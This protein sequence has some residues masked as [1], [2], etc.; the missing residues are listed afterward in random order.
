MN[1]LLLPGNS[2]RHEKWIEDLRK[3]LASHFDITE[4]Q[5]YRHWQSG[6]EKA[7]VDYE[8]SVAQ[9]K[10]DQLKPYTVIAKSI[11]TVIAAKGTAEGKLHP[12]KLILLGIPINGGAPQAPF[13]EWLEKIKLPIVIVQNTNDPLGSF[14]DVRS[15]FEFKNRNILYVELPG[16]THDYLDFRAIENLI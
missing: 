8:L 5:H 9:S 2:Q 10:A 3:A 7:D 16:N 12:N 11:G 15:A 6:E 13:R 14:S 1:A 4:T